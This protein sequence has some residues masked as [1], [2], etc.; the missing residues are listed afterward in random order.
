MRVDIQQA[1]A[2]RYGLRWE[3]PYVENRSAREQIVHWGM[4][5]S[6]SAGILRWQD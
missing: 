5:A 2:I 6:G 4:R 1:P 3:W